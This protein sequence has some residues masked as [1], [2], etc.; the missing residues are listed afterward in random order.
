MFVF[1]LG[2]VAAILSQKLPLPTH[3][4]S[5]W[6]IAGFVALG[7][8]VGG[9]KVS[10][11][12]LRT[13]EEAVSMSLGFAVT[14]ASM[15]R[16][17]PGLAV[18]IAV[19]SCLSS[20]VFPKRQ[21]VHQLIFNVALSAVEALV[22]GLVFTLLNGGT[23]DMQLNFQ[24]CLRTFLAVAC[25]SLSFFLVNTFGVAVMLAL[26][27]GEKL[28]DVWKENF[29][30]TAPSYFAS[31]CVGGLAM[32]LF[33]GSALAVLLFILP[34]AYW[35]YQSFVT[36]IAR[37]EDRQRHIEELQVKQA[38]L[39]DLYL[40]T[41]KS[42]ALAIDAKDQYTHQHIIRVQ[43]Y[44]VAVAIEMGLEGGDLEGVRT[45]ALLH[46]IG[47]L[48]VPEYVLLKPGPLTPE[49]YEKVKKHPEIGAAILDPVEFPW[50]VL[51]VVRHHHERWDGTGYPD[52]L[53]GE[54]I[55]LTARIMAVADVYDAVTSTRSYRQA[56]THERAVE[57][58]RREA[59][60]HFDPVVVESFLK[61]IDRVVN[62]MASEGV[63]PLVLKHA[64]ST[65]VESKAIQAAKHISRASTELWALYEVAQ[66]LSSSLGIKHTAEL[67]VRKI[68]EIYPGATCVFFLWDADVR[69]LTADS[70]FGVNRDFFVNAR[71]VGE[72]SPSLKAIENNTPFFGAFD[73]ADL[74]LDSVAS[75]L[76][77]PPKTALIV[78]VCCEGRPI[79][80]INLYHPSED[81]FSDYDRQLLELIGERAASALYNG[82]L[83]DRTRGDSLSD[84]LTGV[85]NLRFLTNHV[86]SLCD[87]DYAE[88]NESVF[89]LLC[90]DLDSFK[91][92]NDGFGHAKGDAVLRDAARLF[93]EVVGTAGIVAR[94]GGDEFVVVLD[95][96]NQAEAEEMTRRLQEAIETYDP[97]LHHRRLGQLR[98]GVSVGSAC[99]PSDG[100][101][102]A[103][104]LSA[105]DHRMY[106]MKTER[107][108][109]PLAKP[110]EPAGE[111]ENVLPG[112]ER[113]RAGR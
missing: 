69:I 97:Q 53:A 12:S 81:A 11:N 80:T 43:R 66:S 24:N 98:L 71:T 4:N 40:A 1:A 113:P 82:I 92:I 56:W 48:G 85:Y 17:G 79:G 67:V 77:T 62:E 10:L 21:R 107:K 112:L 91:P 41:I 30:W 46:D 105:A 35:V 84:P 101:D 100:K 51:P 25:S 75:G 50:P 61:V 109:Q 55:P 78:P 20:C 95:G 18:I 90:L 33:N 93:T 45:G 103:S 104:L 73:P 106:S 111:R 14:F 52:G 57:L 9:K 87:S 19:A 6:E 110:S 47:K 36:Y 49:E 68:E 7:V 38:Q 28:L 29:K 23:L 96:A 88:A 60:S 5:P 27:T 44:A 54:N 70:A 42:L 58:I 89:A 63:G 31:A 13:N 39:S 37:A 74:M 108:L 72:E 64:V 8:L 2:I 65:A 15:L 26:F 102:C 83:F 94:Y 3:R 99:Y 16:L 22:G 59:G 34:V 76:W 86:D 32:L